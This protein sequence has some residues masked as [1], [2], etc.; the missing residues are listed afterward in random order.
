[1]RRLTPL[2]NGF[3]KV[4]AHANA[5]ALHFMYYNFVRI[6][7]TL[8]VT[9]AMAAGVTDKLWEIGDI[10]APIEAK[11][12]EKPMVRGPYRKHRDCLLWLTETGGAT[13]RRILSVLCLSAL[14]TT[15]GQARPA[16][17]IITYETFWDFCRNRA[18]DEHDR[19]VCTAY[20]LGHVDAAVTISEN[21]SNGPKLCMDFDSIPA[22]VDRVLSYVPSK[23]TSEG[24]VSTLIQAAIL[25]ALAC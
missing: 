17:N 2:T 20:V 18:T 8:R 24:H 1:M 7:A 5:V 3:S 4:E 9:P 25:K 11:E 6:H 14:V 16:V 19:A 23:L 22:L 10:V 15:S 21:M 13:M 12:A